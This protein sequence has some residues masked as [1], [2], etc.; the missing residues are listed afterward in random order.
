MILS[1][2]PFVAISGAFLHYHHILRSEIKNYGYKY[3][4]Q[5]ALDS[6]HYLEDIIK[7]SDEKARN[8]KI[9]GCFARYYNNRKKINEL[10]DNTDMG[11]S[12]AL[13]PTF[14]GLLALIFCFLYQ[15]FEMKEVIV[16]LIISYIIIISLGF[17]CI[18]VWVYYKTSTDFDDAK[19]DISLD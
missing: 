7:L 16:T 2:I 12:F 17:T 8:K 15:I 5:L 14:F 18:T 9:T 13:V 6:Y 10:N 11:F 19:V 1:V 3:F 4:K